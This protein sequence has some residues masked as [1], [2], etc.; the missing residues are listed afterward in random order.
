MAEQQGKMNMK[1]NEYVKILHLKNVAN[2][3]GQKRKNLI[4]NVFKDKN[5]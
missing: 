3:G 5:A 1:Y 4:H 2:L